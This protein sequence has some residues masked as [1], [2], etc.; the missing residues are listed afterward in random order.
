MDDREDKMV[1]Y[2]VAAVGSL[3]AVGCTLIAVWTLAEKLMS[4]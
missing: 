4:Q 1:G 2:Q 3:I